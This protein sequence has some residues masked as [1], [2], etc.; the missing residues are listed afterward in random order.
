MK[1][2]LGAGEPAPDFT[3]RCT[4]DQSVSLNEFRGRP[5][6]LAFYPAFEGSL[7]RGSRYQFMRVRKQSHYRTMAAHRAE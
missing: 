5:V 3:L 7:K 6:V 4:P 1:T 2:I